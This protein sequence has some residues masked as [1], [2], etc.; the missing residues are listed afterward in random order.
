MFNFV[1]WSYFEIIKMHNNPLKLNGILLYSQNTDFLSLGN[2]DLPGNL[3][4]LPRSYFRKML[5]F[6]SILKPNFL[7]YRADSIKLG[8]LEHL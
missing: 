3:A 8:T 7:K 1:N 6:L 2:T 5:F 4:T